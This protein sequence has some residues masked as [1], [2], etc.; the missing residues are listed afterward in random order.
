MTRTR[1]Y[2][3]NST[4]YATDQENIMKLKELGFI[5]FLINIIGG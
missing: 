1:C 4:I 2:Y 3:I 5:V